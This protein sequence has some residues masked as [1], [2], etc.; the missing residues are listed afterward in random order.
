MAIESS[1]TLNG[2]KYNL[3]NYHTV[4]ATAAVTSG[5]VKRVVVLEQDGNTVGG[6]P[7]VQNDEVV[8]Q[9]T[10]P[11][12]SLL[13]NITIYCHE[14]PTTQTGASLGW[15][16]GTSSSGAE[17]C[18]GD[19]VDGLIDVGTDGTDLAVGGLALC[20]DTVGGHTLNRQTLDAVTLA[21]DVNFTSADRT[22]YFTTTETSDKSIT[23]AGKMRWIIE[24]YDLSGTAKSGPA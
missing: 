3:D 2:L 22:L 17:I 13:T 24:Y 18:T 4:A 5:D 1:I 8:T 12:Y 23:T 11:A 15:E 7:W 21:A 6:A 9:W 16:V 14:A 10:Q 19:A 20:G